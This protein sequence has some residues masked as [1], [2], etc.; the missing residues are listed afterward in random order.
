[1]IGT[2]GGFYWN[3]DSKCCHLSGHGSQSSSRVRRWDYYRC[4][5][6][7]V[8]FPKHQ[9]LLP[10]SFSRKSYV[11]SKSHT[12]PWNISSF[13]VDMPIK[14]RKC[15]IYIYIYIYN[16]IFLI[17]WLFEDFVPFNQTSFLISNIFNR[18][19]LESYWIFFNDFKRCGKG[20]VSAF[21]RTWSHA[22][23][24]S[25]L[26]DIYDK[27]SPIKRHRESVY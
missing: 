11:R 7:T 4:K 23:T 8:S 14:K 16:H 12:K 27:P 24:R 3:K 2:F 9:K 18:T 17:Y 13:S 22:L 25:E 1:M 15:Y 10:N 5:A 26:E 19:V 6:E 21:Q 20:T